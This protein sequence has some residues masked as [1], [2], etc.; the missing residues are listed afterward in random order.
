[1]KV[2]QT[3][4][5]HKP[6]TEFYGGGSYPRCKTCDKEAGAK[7]KTESPVKFEHSRNKK[8]LKHAYG[9][10]WEDY[11]ELSETQDNVCKICGRG[12]KGW[13]LAVDHCHKTGRIRGLLCNTCNRALGLFQD[14]PEL[15]DK[16]TNYLK[17]N[18]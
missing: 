1:M 12:N 11:L 18:N 8:R 9:L 7:Y 2:C 3:C 5:K 14:N 16:A 10:E 15:T 4:K 6:R 17:E 13:L